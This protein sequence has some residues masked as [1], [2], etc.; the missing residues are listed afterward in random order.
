MATTGQLEEFPYNEDTSGGDHSLHG[1]GFVQS[2][3]GG[4]VRSSSYLANANKR[5]NFTVL[6][7]VTVEKLPETGMR[8]NLKSFLSI[9]FSVS[10]VMQ[11]I[12]SR[13]LTDNLFIWFH[14]NDCDGS[15]RSYPF[16]WH[17]WNSENTPQQLEPGHA[18]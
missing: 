17:D 14:P 2:S 16:C 3:A 15:Q 8:G 5:P 12:S 10:P 18:V 9:Q 4:G 6:I 13:I 11:F 7:N 1:I